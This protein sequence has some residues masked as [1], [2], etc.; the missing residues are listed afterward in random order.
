MTV[1]HLWQSYLWSKLSSFPWPLKT[2]ADSTEQK[3]LSERSLFSSHNP[4]PEWYTE[5]SL[6][7]LPLSWSLKPG[8][9]LPLFLQRNSLCS[10]MQKIVTLGPMWEGRY[11][12]QEGEAQPVSIFQSLCSLSYQSKGEKERYTHLNAEF[13]RIARRD[14]KAFFSDQCKEI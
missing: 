4:A 14:K 7:P 13:Q 12:R 6:S 11:L 5:W 3:M 1:L 8:P 2:L 10:K 9:Y